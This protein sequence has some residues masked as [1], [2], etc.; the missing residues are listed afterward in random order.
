MVLKNMRRAESKVTWPL[1]CPAAK[2]QKWLLSVYYY[3][4]K[5]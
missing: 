3:Y 4:Y 5:W 1:V 2:R